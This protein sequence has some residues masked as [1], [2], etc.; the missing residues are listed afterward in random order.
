MELPES[1]TNMPPQ[2]LLLIVGGGI[3]AGLLW[4]KYANKGGAA[5]TGGSSANPYDSMQGAGNLGAFGSSL[6]S[7]NG[8]NDSADRRDVFGSGINLPVTEWVIV[9][10][11]GKRYLTNGETITPLDTATA[12]TPIGGTAPADNYLKVDIAPPASRNVL[13]APNANR[14]PTPIEVAVA[15]TWFGIRPEQAYALPLAEKQ[16]LVSRYETLRLQGQAP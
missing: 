6:E 9:G 13:I 1:V 11:D 3:A 2:R 8:T 7:T 4:R 15:G 10:A 14:M 5:T 16:S 12:T